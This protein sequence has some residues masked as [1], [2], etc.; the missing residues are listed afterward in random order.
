MHIR[1][2]LGWDKSGSGMVLSK[3]LMSS[4]VIDLLP[5]CLSQASFALESNFNLPSK[6]GTD[7][8]SM[9]FGTMVNLGSWLVHRCFGRLGVPMTP[10]G[11]F[12]SFDE[13]DM[14]VLKRVKKNKIEEHYLRGLLV[15]LFF[16]LGG[17]SHFRF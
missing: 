7:A 4:H 16:F 12:H 15:I 17:I 3:G 8:N 13:R 2:Q 9:D 6:E 14:Q 1:K 5:A 11:G 10:S